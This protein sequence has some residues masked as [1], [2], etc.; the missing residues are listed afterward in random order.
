MNLIKTYLLP[1]IILLFISVPTFSQ[2]VAN[3]DDED[4]KGVQISKV[5]SVL[6][7]HYF[8]EQEYN[9]IHGIDN[10]KTYLEPGDL[11]DDEIYAD[12]K[13]KK[14]GGSAFWKDVPADIVIDAVVHTL[15]LVTLFWQ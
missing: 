1:M 7:N 13:Y 14:K 8:T 15:I 10:L 5:D 2:D 12:K 11:Y 3:N 4:K 9:M 6:E